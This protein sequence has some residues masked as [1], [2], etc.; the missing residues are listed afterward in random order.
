MPSSR[1]ARQPRLSGAALLLSAAAK[2]GSV[3]RFRRQQG[4]GRRRGELRAAP[5]RGGRERLSL[6][7][8]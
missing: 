1:E 6:R 5:P 8:L 4:P 2:W 7:A 3:G